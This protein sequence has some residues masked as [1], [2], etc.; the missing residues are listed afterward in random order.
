MVKNLP[1]SEGHAG[2][3][4]CLGTKIPHAMGTLSP[5]TATTEPVDHNLR[6][7]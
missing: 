7:A 2:L 1:S 3:I 6:E 4:P 5:N